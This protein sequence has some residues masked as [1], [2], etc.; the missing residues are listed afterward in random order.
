[1]NEFKFFGRLGADPEIKYNQ[2]GLAITSIRMAV[3][4]FKMVSKGQW[5]KETDWFTVDFVGDKAEKL[6]QKYKKGRQILVSGSVHPWS[7]ETDG[8]KKKGFNFSG[9][10][11]FYVDEKNRSGQP[12]Q[13]AQTQRQSSVDFGE[14]EIPF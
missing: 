6:A 1:M 14:D 12:E 2:N 3:D 7:V 13:P 11:F 8:Q 10:Q 9:K 4:K 5:E